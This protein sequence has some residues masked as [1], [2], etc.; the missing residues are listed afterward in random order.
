MVEQF[1]EIVSRFH[2]G[3]ILVVGFFELGDEFFV[4]VVE[5]SE[6]GFEFLVF[7]FF[8]FGFGFFGVILSELLFQIAQR[9]GIWCF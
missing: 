4:V 7:G 5:F 1:V 3:E 6:V 9:A 8:Q 2:Q